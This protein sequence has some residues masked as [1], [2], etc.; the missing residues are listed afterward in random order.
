MRSS[1]QRW[2][3]TI[4]RSTSCSLNADTIV[5][6]D[7][8]DILIAF[9]DNNPA[10]G[11]AASMEITPDG[12]GRSVPFRFPS[13]A[14]ELDRG[15]RLGIVS[16]L[17]SPW[18]I[19]VPVVPQKACR[20]EWVC[21]ASVMLRRTMLEQI[22]LLDEGLYTYWD[23]IDLCLRANQAGWE[24]WFVP[25]SS[26]VHLVGAST[27]VTGS[28]PPIRRPPYWFQARRRFY[29]KHYGPWYTAMADG[30]FILGC[31]VWRLRR[32]SNVSRTPTRRTYSSTRFAIASSVRDSR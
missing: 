28:W 1:D 30:A 27:G 20:A 18:G 19:I 15:L 3:R 16:K 26:V 22:G 11:I 13:I 17:L 21:F 24:T 10:V 7:A 9:M 12:R 29:L 8:L 32:G 2:S 6:K 5:Q 31:A 25:E 4:P 14:S 23:D